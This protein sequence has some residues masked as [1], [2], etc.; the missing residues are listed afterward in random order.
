M[1]TIHIKLIDCPIRIVID[2]T[3]ELDMQHYQQ[4]AKLCMTIAKN[5]HVHYD[6]IKS[7][8]KTAE[9]CKARRGLVR[10]AS[11]DHHIPMYAIAEFLGIDVGGVKHYL[12]G[13]Q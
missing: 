6:M 3:P 5:Y 10:V 11:I 7:H 2:N 13:I 8:R 1:K 12:K 4:L 9:I